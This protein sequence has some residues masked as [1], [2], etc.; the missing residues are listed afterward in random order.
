MASLSDGGKMWGWRD[1]GGQIGP[2]NQGKD[3]ALTLSE[4]RS[5]ETLLSRDMTR[6]VAEAPRC[7]KGWVGLSKGIEPPLSSP[8]TVL[9]LSSQ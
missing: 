9:F 2:G 1:N 4:M 6:E 5:D 8:E 3:L 7:R